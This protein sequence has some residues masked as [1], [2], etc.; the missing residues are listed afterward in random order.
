MEKLVI[1]IPEECKKEAE[2]LVKEIKLEQIFSKSLPR[3][4]EI[5]LKKELLRNIVSK[6]ELKEEEAKELA[7]EVKEGIAKEACRKWERHGL[8]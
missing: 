8:K 6:S 2:R 7:E 3:C 4:F 1:E 5:E